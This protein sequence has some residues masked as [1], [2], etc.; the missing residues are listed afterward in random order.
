MTQ[1]TP[2]TKL[3]ADKLK[4]RIYETRVEM[5]DEAAKDVAEKIKE[6]LQRQPTVN[7]IFAAAPSQNEFLD[8]LSRYEEINWNRV[9][10]FHMDEYIG[11][12]PRAVQSFAYFLKEK[13]F[14]RVS[15]NAVHYIDGHAAD[16]VLECQRYARL[17]MENQPDIVCM[18]IG[19]NTHI[20]FN[21]P[22]TA[23]FN[24]P[25]L[26]KVVKLDDASRQQQVHDE[27]FT[28]LQNVPESAITLTVPAL[29]KAHSIFC[30]VPGSNK[31]D[32]V[33]HTINDKVQEEYPSTSLKL[34]NDATLYLDSD[35][36]GRL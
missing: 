26:V 14:D 23:D 20:A 24:D 28:T 19:E 2:I 4:V 8:A 36:A 15:F 16:P 34:H 10:G 1:T 3:F 27:C 9:N 30:I 5:G 13:I 22:H 35:S 6:L 17:L 31:A 11:L 33:T 12:P 7:I 29:L 21:D 32:A 18:G 25:F